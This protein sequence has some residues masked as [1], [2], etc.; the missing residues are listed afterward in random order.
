M[1][2]ILVVVYILV[3]VDIL[4]LGVQLGMQVDDLGKY[5]G[6]EE[7]GL[8]SL[9]MHYSYLEQILGVG[10]QRVGILGVGILVAFLFSLTINY[11]LI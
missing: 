7:V 1:V 6:L 8:D 10:N 4:A 3:V 9:P 5:S 11:N 2:D